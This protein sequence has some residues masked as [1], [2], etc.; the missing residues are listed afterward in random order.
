LIDAAPSWIWRPANFR[1]LGPLDVHFCYSGGGRRSVEINGREI[2][3]GNRRRDP[4]IERR[5]ET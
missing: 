2:L 4:S 5:R 1:Q 3:V